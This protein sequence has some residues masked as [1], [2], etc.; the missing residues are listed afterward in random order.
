VPKIMLIDYAVS[1]LLLLLASSKA[2][3]MD[4]TPAEM[5]NNF[6]PCLAPLS[7]NA[8]LGGDGQGGLQGLLELDC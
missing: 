4:L 5:L 8:V 2:G 6:C 1:W 3:A 7:C